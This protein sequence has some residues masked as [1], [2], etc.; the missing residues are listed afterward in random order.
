MQFVLFVMF[1]FVLAAAKSAPQRKS[2]KRA[3]SSFFRHEQFLTSM[4]PAFDLRVFFFVFLGA[5]RVNR[6]RRT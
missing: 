2:L 3:Q 5:R 1:V 4:L 6:K